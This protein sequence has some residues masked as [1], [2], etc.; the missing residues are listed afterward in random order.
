MT[1]R[2]GRESAIRRTCAAGALVLLLATS[3]TPAPKTASA[4]SSPLPR[5]A[6]AVDRLAYSG[7]WEFVHGRRDGRYL[8]RS[9]RS[10]HPGDALTVIYDGEGFRL[11]GVAGPNGGVGT[12]VLPGQS[13]QQ[14]SFYSPQ[15]RPHVLLYT[16]PR[17]NSG[18]H[19]AGV[20]VTRPLK[21][22]RGYVNIDEVQIVGQGLL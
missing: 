22:E 6:G 5:E 18:M 16:S 19:S 10:Y 17:M 3:C 1:L 13:S 14:I 20:V 7:H 4:S 9:A 15:R 2:A 11:F 21:R 8:G 12:V